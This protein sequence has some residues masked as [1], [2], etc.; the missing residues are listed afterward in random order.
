MTISILTPLLKKNF[1]LAPQ[2]NWTKMYNML[3]FLLREDQ[4]TMAA[5]KNFALEEKLVILAEAESSS[6]TKIVAVCRRYAISKST[7]DY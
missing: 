7:L 4:E 6:T 2:E 5:H 3:K 1:S